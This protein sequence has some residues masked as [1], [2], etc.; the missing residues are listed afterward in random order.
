[1]L[2]LL[3]LRELR[4]RHLEPREQRFHQ[5]AVRRHVATGSPAVS[6]SLLQPRGLR[7]AELLLREVHVLGQV[8]VALGAI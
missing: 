8:E 6:T 1:M 2:E 3:W 5:R 7:R 4:S